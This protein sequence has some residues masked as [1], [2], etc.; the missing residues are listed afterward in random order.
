MRINDPSP[1]DQKKK[2]THEVDP[3]GCLPTTFWEKVI[4]LQPRGWDRTAL[5]QTRDIPNFVAASSP[6]HETTL[7]PSVQY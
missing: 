2:K 4:K 3:E 1:T 6:V 7:P 5:K